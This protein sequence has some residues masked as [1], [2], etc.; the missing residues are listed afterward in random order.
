MEIQTIFPSS[1]KNGYQNL[2]GEAKKEK[3]KKKEERSDKFK[4]NRVKRI[5]TPDFKT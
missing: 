3:K 1:Q 5:V 4:E 2:Y